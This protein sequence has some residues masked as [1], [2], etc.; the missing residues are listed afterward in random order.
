MKALL[1]IFNIAITDKIMKILKN[2]ELYAYTLIEKIKGKGLYGE[3]H[4]GTHTWPELNSAIFTVAK[5]E[6]IINAFKE[7]KNLDK[8]LPKFGIKAY[9]FDV[10]DYF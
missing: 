8:E 6:N 9:V 3:P 5:K 1:I 4:F 10:F 7:L 2:N